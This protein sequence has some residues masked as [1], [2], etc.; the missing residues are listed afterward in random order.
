MV[1]RVP[2]HFQRNFQ[3]H[4]LLPIQYFSVQ[5]HFL[6]EVKSVP[7]RFHEHETGGCHLPGVLCLPAANFLANL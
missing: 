2:I 6:T 4:L 3:A 5:F 7:L 1:V